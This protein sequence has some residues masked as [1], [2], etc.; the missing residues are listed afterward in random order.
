MI[1]PS[2]KSDLRVILN[3][4]IQAEGYFAR[5]VHIEQSTRKTE[6]RQKAVASLIQSGISYHRQ[7]AT[8]L[9]AFLARETA[10]PEVH[11]AIAERTTGSVSAERGN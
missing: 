11:S 8:Y 4:H 9:E 10:I 2:Q 5:A 1:T 6:A 3:L 7:A